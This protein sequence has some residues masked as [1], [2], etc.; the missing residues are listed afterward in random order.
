MWKLD[1]AERLSAWR[2]FR[3]LLD[4]QS[5]SLALESTAQFWQTPPF[6]PYYLD[7]TNTSNWPDPWTL[8][9][10]NYYCDIAKALGMLYTIAL[11]RHSPDLTLRIYY[12]TQARVNYNLVWV[13][14]GKYVLNMTDG[15][16][17]NRKQLPNTFELKFEYNSKE[18]IEK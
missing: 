14:D 2:D 1:V 6:S 7:P 8:I 11:T 18:L 4:E 17:V 12:D 9:S 5:L 3:R 16:V 10:E 15:E 13:E